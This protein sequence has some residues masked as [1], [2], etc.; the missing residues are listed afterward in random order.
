M[1]ILTIIGFF[2]DLIN[3]GGFVDWI[4]EIFYK[5]L[6]FFD[7]LA[8]MLLAYSY[9]L[10]QLMCTLNFNS[11]YG[12]I[13][14][15]LTRIEA[16]VMVFV[17]YK[18]GISLINFML[19]PEEASK[20][21]K[22][23]LI[24][25]FITAALL[26]SYNTIFTLFNELSMLIIGTPDNYNFVVLGQIA[27]ITGGKDSGLINRIVFGTAEEMPDIGEYIAFSV[28]ST[29]ITDAKDPQNQEPLKQALN[30]NGHI[31]FRNLPQIAGDIGK[32]FDY[33]YVVGFAAACYM[34]YAFI[35]TTIQ[36]GVRAFKLLILQV[37]APIAIITIIGEGIKGK[38]FS[39]FVK[40]YS[41]V[42]VEVFIRM[43]SM[44]LV[45]NFVVKF[46]R[47]ITDYFPAINSDEWYTVALMIILI[48][49]AAFKF[50]GDIPSFI[51]EI[52]H[53]EIETKKRDFMPFLKG[54]VGGVAGGTIGGLVGAVG[55]FAGGGIGGAIAGIGSGITGGARS[56]AK[57]KNVADFFKGQGQVGKDTKA[58]GQN[59]AARGGLIQ[60][61]IGN[62]QSAAG[63]GNAQDRK[64]AKL[65]RQSAALDALDSA[66]KFAVKDSKM[67]TV[68]NDG[69]LTSQ[70]DQTWGASQEGYD[71]DHAADYF[72]D[73]YSGG[74]S[75]VKL[76]EDKDAYAAK[77]LDYDKAYQQAQA[78]YDSI[79]TTDLSS[80][81]SNISDADRR[82]AEAQEQLDSAT[83]DEDRIA[84]QQLL[85]EMQQ[86][87]IEAEER[88]AAQEKSIADAKT[89]AEVARHNAEKR[90]KD[91][92]D[93]RKGFEGDHSADVRSK[94]QSYLDAGG[95][96]A[97]GKNRT[98]EK[99][100]I[101]EEKAAIQNKPSYQRTHGGNPKNK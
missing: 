101:H 52:L 17:V 34:I 28:C 80:Y 77:M 72:R 61:G 100:R 56:G 54:L 45:C 87:K 32:K 40:K 47:N 58:K 21:G 43:F 62:V 16:L 8:Y 95:R 31:E 96:D 91:Y 11:L 92:Y 60:T 36:V 35:K 53:L 46:I 48:I 30:D 2:T 90:A 84:G 5:A 63:V 50:A 4:T 33:F 49:I 65:D 51:N 20:K 7:G 24:N 82:V 57:G 86:R 44:L 68:D 66:E 99:R 93:A 15:I 27:D 6:L 25:I 13:S 71:A 98:D 37:V 75:D 23:I 81:R 70:F 18:L 69:H 42:Y 1:N 67:G 89:A 38:T 94:R 74:Y 3:I 12:L 10:F 59:I 55:G 79:S 29:F 73:T 64:I 39:A 78:A 83:T 26:L 97:S 85:E 76:G 14:G 22:E 41:A 19:N 88:L 9:K